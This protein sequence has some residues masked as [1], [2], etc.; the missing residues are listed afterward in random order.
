MLTN[1][2]RQRRGLC[3]ALAMLLMTAALARKISAAVPAGLG[4]ENAG[5]ARPRSSLTRSPS[6]EWSAAFF[7]RRCGLRPALRTSCEW[8]I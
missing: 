1:T 4:P 2:F 3:S 6:A 8:I 5:L 7:K